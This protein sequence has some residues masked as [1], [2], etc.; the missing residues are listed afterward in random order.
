MKKKV[1]IVS[2]SI[3]V[4]L[5]IC[6]IGIN[7][8]NKNRTYQIIITENF[9]DVSGNKYYENVLNKNIKL[10]DEIKVND[11]FGGELTFKVIKANNKLIVIKTS[12]EMS[13]IKENS[14]VQKD[15]FV[16]KKNEETIINRL[17]SGKG[18]SYT[19]IVK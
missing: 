19:M 7:L 14:L 15:E 17:L 2:I 16:I 11:G 8:Y 1:I 9:F 3:I 10:K 13:Q 6:Y 12:E 5:L 18:V 4:I